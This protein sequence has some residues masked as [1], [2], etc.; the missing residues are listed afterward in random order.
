MTSQWIPQINSMKCIGCGN[1]IV[2][3]PTGALGKQ[4]GKS[5]VIQ[6]GN[7]TYCAVCET[8]CPVSAIELPYLIVKNEYSKETRDA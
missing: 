3:C 4:A 5:T 1:C 2:S 7:C 8:V 6:S